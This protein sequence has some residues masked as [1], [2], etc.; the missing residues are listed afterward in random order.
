MIERR[1]L[2]FGSWYVGCVCGLYL[3]VFVGLLVVVGWCQE[4][5]PTVVAILAAVITSLGWEWMFI[6]QWF[7]CEPFLL[8]GLFQGGVVVG[9][10][11]WGGVFG[12][13]CTYVGPGSIIW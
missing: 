2:W 3:A 5:M 7:R 11:G 4:W 13:Y 6:M 10:L 12:S 8:K 1:A 9:I